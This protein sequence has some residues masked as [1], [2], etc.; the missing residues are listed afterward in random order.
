MPLDEATEW[1]HANGLVQRNVDGEFSDE[2]A[3]GK[4]ISQFPAA[5]DPAD[6]DPVD[7]T[8]S[9]GRIETPVKYIIDFYPQVAPGQLIKVYI[10]DEEGA[11]V[12]FEGEYEGDAIKTEESDRKNCFNGI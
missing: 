5:G 4:V 3:E 12:V 10:E 11:K 8:V 7:L 6:G 1:L 2:F 9:K